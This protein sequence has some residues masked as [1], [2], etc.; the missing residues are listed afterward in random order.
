M[1]ETNSASPEQPV[2]PAEAVE[3]GEL[4][5]PTSHHEPEHEER[6]SVTEPAKVMTQPELMIRRSSR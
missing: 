1:S 5:E 3:R 6:G 2:A 4:I